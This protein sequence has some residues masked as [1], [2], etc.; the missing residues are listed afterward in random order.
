MKKKIVIVF[1]IIL[2]LF[3]LI[4]NYSFADFYGDDEDSQ[5]TS[6]PINDGKVP[7]DVEELTPDV[8]GVQN[9]D[10][11]G[12]SVLENLTKGKTTLEK[13]KSGGFAL[14]TKSFNMQ[15]MVENSSSSTSSSFVSA[16]TFIVGGWLNN[17]P[18]WVVEATGSEMPEDENGKTYFTIYDLVIG[19]YEFFNL[20][21]SKMDTIVKENNTAMIEKINVKVLKF[22]MVLR[23]LSLA[24]C[25]FI[26]LYIAIRMALSTSSENIAKYKNMLIAWFTSMLLIFFMHYIIIII[27]YIAN[28]ALD[29]IKRIAEAW[30]VENIEYSI[31]KGDI[32][33]VTTS[34]GTG[35]QL[36]SALFMVTI[37]VY[38]QVKFLFAYIKRYCEIV[39]LISISPLVCSAYAI[40][41]V[42]DNRA[43]SFS[44]WIKEISVRYALQIVHAITYVVFIASAGEIAKAMPVLAIFFLWGMGK[45][46]KISRKVIGLQGGDH[47]EKAKPP[48]AP[49]F[50]GLGR[51]RHKR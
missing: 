19:N 4:C 34:A 12:G 7:E 9:K 14:Q 8:P 50:P 39:F 29:V 30:E 28:W 3:N 40:D 48:K 21:F 22:Y 33:S 43:Q 45:A 44:I 42:G 51:F 32:A 23:N 46:D 41:K 17:I 26:L 13:T 49:R 38:Y 47:L 37:F 24:L 6:E 35:M 10:T 5:E 25:V 31:F 36:I 1:T 27:S 11:F 20:N 15:T 2:M 16:W 18:Q